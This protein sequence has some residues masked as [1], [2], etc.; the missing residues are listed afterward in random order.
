MPRIRSTT[1]TGSEDNLEVSDMRDDSLSRRLMMRRLAAI[2][3][4][5]ASTPLLATLDADAKAKGKGKGK[6]KGKQQRKRRTPEKAKEEDAPQPEQPE[7][8]L[9]S[10]ADDVEGAAK[11]L[12]ISNLAYLPIPTFYDKDHRKDGV[13]LR[14]GSPLGNGKR[15]VV[16]QGYIGFAREHATLMS[17]YR[18]TFRITCEGWG[19]DGG[20]AAPS[21]KEFTLTLPYPGAIYTLPKGSPANAFRKPFTFYGDVASSDLNEDVDDGIFDTCDDD[22]D[23][24]AAYL[25]V[26][27]LP[28]GRGWSPVTKYRTNQV[29]GYF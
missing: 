14:I 2:G 24:I 11:D 16:V 12:K 7:G 19:I 20:C 3:L 23:D 10:P 4:V 25:I 15:R 8:S 1:T 22:Q 17:T 28:P 13:V 5:A 27:A 21:D 26:E 6:G 18:Y 9:P 29:Q